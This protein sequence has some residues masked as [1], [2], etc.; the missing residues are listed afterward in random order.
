MPVDANFRH[1]RRLL[2]I[3]IAYQNEELIAD[4]AFPIVQIPGQGTA[5]EY[6]KYR[7]GEAYSVPDT[8]MGRTSDAR[9]VEHGF[10]TIESSTK[11]Y[12]LQEPV[13]KKEIENAQDGYDP[14][15]MAG[16]WTM[17]LVKLDRERR[18]AG[19][20][21]NPNHY[22][23]NQKIVLSGT[24][25]FSDPTSD[26]VRV[27]TDALDAMVTRANKMILGQK[28]ATAL[29]R[30]PKIV[31]SFQARTGLDDNAVSLV[32]LSYLQQLFFN[33]KIVVGQAHI[34]GGRPN[35]VTAPTQQRVW[36]PHIALVRHEPVRLPYSRTFS[37]TAYSKKVAM[38]YEDPK[39]GLE[40]GTRVKMGEVLEEIICEP[41][42]GFFIEDAA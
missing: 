33:I 21:F 9:E 25:K 26:P 1:D 20:M 12:G 24:S 41:N 42:F 19:L 22:P 4:E 3:A 16:E 36:G 14:L 7:V 31:A 6:R 13:P 17:G 40:G 34:T 38:K 29:C 32:P 18:C 23:T 8:T 27:I 11:D 28:V 2:S 37:F 30:H 39:I 15:G 5:Y 35:T 10:D